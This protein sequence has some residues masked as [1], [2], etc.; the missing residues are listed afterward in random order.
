MAHHAAPIISAGL[1]YKERSRKGESLLNLVGVVER[2]RNRVESEIEVGEVG[3]H[4]GF[5]EQRIKKPAHLPNERKLF[6]PHYPS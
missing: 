3:G 6:F 2:D 4:L 5:Y 1:S